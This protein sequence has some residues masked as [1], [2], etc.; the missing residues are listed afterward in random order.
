MSDVRDSR[1]IVVDARK[2]L[3]ARSTSTPGKTWELP[4]KAIGAK[5]A[6]SKEELFPAPDLLSLKQATPEILKSTVVP[7]LNVPKGTAEK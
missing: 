3:E 6:R 5:K 7:F 2:S 1:G 4:A